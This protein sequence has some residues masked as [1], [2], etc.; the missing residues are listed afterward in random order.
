VKKAL[1]IIIGGALILFTI[2]LGIVFP[3]LVWDWY[4]YSLQ[5][6]QHIIY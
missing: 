5:E 2:G 3:L 4:W 6:V 1:T